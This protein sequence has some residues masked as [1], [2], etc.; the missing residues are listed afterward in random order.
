MCRRQ[1]GQPV[2]STEDLVGA[3]CELAQMIHSDFLYRLWL[4][5]NGPF[6]HY[7]PVRLDIFCN[8]TSSKVH[9]EE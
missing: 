6:I 3:F 4:S 7:I 2:T 9:L 1:K 8:L 5:P